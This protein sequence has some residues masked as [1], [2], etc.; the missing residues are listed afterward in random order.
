MNEIKVKI[1]SI[2][3][4]IKRGVGEEK[5][6]LAVSGGIDSSV[7]AVLSHRVIPNQLYL[8][9]IRTGFN[10]ESEEKKLLSLFRRMDARIKVIDKQREYFKEL[11]DIEDPVKR[12]YAFG[13]ISLEIIKGYAD[14][15]NASVLI[16]GVIKND[17]MLP[18]IIKSCRKRSNDLKRVSGLKLAEPIADLYKNDVK[19]IAESIGL[20]GLVCKQHIPGPGLSIRISGKITEEKLMLL[21]KINNFLHERIGYNKMFWQYFPF[22]LDEKLDNKHLIVLRFVSSNDGLKAE[23]IYDGRVMRCLARD[24]IKRFPEVGRVF[25][26]I[27]P[28]PP[29]TI[30]FM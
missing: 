20:E 15:V 9:Y 3:K 29:A 22:L 5:A 2:L 10:L 30:E 11:K 14:S 19:R 21:K 12:R 27:S 25:F 4:R 23:P 16:N 13:R 17:K 18:D 8:L 6:V 28:K 26:D 7:C 24:I 1:D